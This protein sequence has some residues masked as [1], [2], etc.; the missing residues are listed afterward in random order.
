MTTK[1][2][3]HKYKNKNGR[4][5]PHAYA[6]NRHND[7]RC[8]KY[9]FIESMLFSRFIGFSFYNYMYGDEFTLRVY[10]PKPFSFVKI[11]NIFFV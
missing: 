7:V 4:S 1:C 6:D 10:R 2:E 8:K 5:R 11:I 9:T 3:I